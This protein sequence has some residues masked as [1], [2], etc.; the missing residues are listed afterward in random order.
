MVGISKILCSTSEPGDVIRYTE[1]SSAGPA[2]VVFNCT[3]QCNLSCRHCYASAGNSAGGDGELTTDGIIR[4]IDEL[5][6]I[7]TSV[8]LFSGGEPL[9]RDDIF[10]IVAHAGRRNLHA[11]LSTNGTLITPQTAKRFADIGLD[12]IGVSIDA[13]QP[14]AND[15]FRR[16]NGAFDMACQGIINA[17]N[18]GIRCGLRFTMTRQNIS[19]IPAIFSMAENLQINRICF[20]HLVP[21]GRAGA[22]LSPDSW[23]IRRGLDEIITHTQRLHDAGKAMEVLTVD[24]H[25]DGAYLYL[26]LLA[27]GRKQ[28]AELALKLLKK[29]GGNASGRKICCVSWD[30]DVYPDQFWR[31]RPLGNINHKN[32]NEIWH[33][34]TCDS[35]L[36]QL[37]DR[38]SLLN[39]RCK[40]CRFLDIC[41]GNLRAR[42]EHAG[43]G[44]WGDDTAC[45]LT[46]K[47][48]AHV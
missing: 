6:D 22:S 5:A 32:F 3:R 39:G 4:L 31:N 26:K 18:A 48:I 30:G 14:E 10:D 41:N 1:S 24:N 37:R 33:D 8:I 2:V 38:H 20:Y 42:A 23:H 9:M 28:H 43:N 13:A 34:E 46:D 29:A 17:R 21:V 11:V 27:S 25:A 15:D 47:E 7:G 44:I 36:R 40:K 16:W 12:Y 19:H 35:L 45:Y